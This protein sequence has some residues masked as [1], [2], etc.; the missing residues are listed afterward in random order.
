M[1]TLIMLA[2]AVIAPTCYASETV[3]FNAR[4]KPIAK[5]ATAEVHTAIQIGD[6]TEGEL[7]S[8]LVSMV[9]RMP[10]EMYLAASSLGVAIC[11]PKTLTEDG[12]AGC[13][14]SSILG[15]GQAKTE[16][17]IGG[18]LIPEY[19][20]LTPVMGPPLDR[21]TRLLDYAVGYSPVAG[22]SV[23]TS[24]V[25]ERTGPFGSELVTAVPL[26]ASVPGAAPISIVSLEYTIDPPNLRYYSW[27]HGKRSSYRPRGISIPGRCPAD[28]YRFSASLTFLDKSTVTASTTVPCSEAGQSRHEHH[29]GA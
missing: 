10:P 17:E 3:T 1:A 19:S 14:R 26:I 5:T 23:S 2:G 11:T 8:P 9:T 4:I 25:A 29:G 18:T 6:S 20:S 12:P 13:P 27:R 22:E 16:S 28:G 15:Y 7:P 24:T 21:H